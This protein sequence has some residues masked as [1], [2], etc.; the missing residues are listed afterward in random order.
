MSKLGPLIGVPLLLILALAMA[1]AVLAPIPRSAHPDFID[2][3]LA[4]RAVVSAIRIAII[5]AA[6]FVAL[7][8]IALAAQRRWLT[9]L[10]PV[11]VSEEVAGFRL[12]IRQLEGELEAA[13]QAIDALEGRDVHT[14]QLVDR[15]K[16]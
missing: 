10:G 8:V 2:A 15:G 14:H 6:I 16:G 5:F 3:V 9:R 12:E 1:D 11:E 7:S 4:S 13:L